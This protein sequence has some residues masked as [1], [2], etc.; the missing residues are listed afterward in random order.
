LASPLYQNLVD[1][2]RANHD[3]A[4]RFRVNT[5]QPLFF[6][7]RARVLVDAPRHEP[8]AVLTAVESALKHAF[9]FELRGF[10]QRATAAEVDAAIQ[11]VPGVLA[12]DL[13]Q[14]FLYHDDQPPPDPAVEIIAD[15]L[16]ARPARRH[17]T[18]TLLAELLLINP[19]GISL[20]EMKP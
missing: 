20:E 6:N 12:A 9:S 19:V 13:H 11:G 2:I 17:G 14:L 3:P 15:V 18:E 5:Y 10:A 16:E 1:A 4:H 7:V 8:L